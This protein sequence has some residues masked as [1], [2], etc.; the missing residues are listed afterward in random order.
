MNMQQQICLGAKFLLQHYSTTSLLVY[1]LRYYTSSCF[2]AVVVLP[3][4]HVHQHAYWCCC[5]RQ[6]LFSSFGG[7][8]KRGGGGTCLFMI[9]MST[10]W[11]A[12]PKEQ[13]LKH[14]N[15]CLYNNQRFV[16]TSINIYLILD[17]CVWIET[18]WVSKSRVPSSK[19]EERSCWW[20][21]LGDK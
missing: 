21:P 13:T 20:K 18:L 10:T 12:S 1:C 7:E 3:A 9:Q 15:G 19:D 11:Q 6:S 2:C 14:N 4:F 16:A 5:C 17:M 8:K